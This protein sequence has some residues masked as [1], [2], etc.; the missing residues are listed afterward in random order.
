[1]PRA[2][3]VEVDATGVPCAV[4]FEGA[5]RAVASVQDRWR[6]DEEWWRETAVSRMYYQLQLEGGRVVTLY[7]DLIGGA[8]KEQ[9]Y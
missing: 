7:C 3:A 9:Q 6:I 5:M 2:L 8:W 4:R 1:L